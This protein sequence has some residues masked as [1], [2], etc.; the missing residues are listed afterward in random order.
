M[1]RNGLVSLNLSSS[2]HSTT[3]HKTQNENQNNPWWSMTKP[4]KKPIATNNPTTTI[5]HNPTKSIH[6]PLPRNTFPS[7]THSK[8]NTS[9]QP[10]THEPTVTHSKINPKPLPT[11]TTITHWERERG[12]RGRREGRERHWGQREEI[13]F[14]MDKVWLQIRL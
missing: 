11:I 8:I 3:R 7:K 13:D 12:L 14:L 5:T 10:Q 1:K 2:N 6:N 4:T 9:T